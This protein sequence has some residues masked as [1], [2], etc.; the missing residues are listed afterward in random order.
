MESTLLR[1][2]QLQRSG[3]LV[4][5]GGRIPVDLQLSD[6]E[7]YPRHGY[8]ESAENRLNPETGS[9]VL[10]FVFANPDNA[11]IPGLFARVRLPVSR[12]QPT[13]LVQRT[14]DPGRT[15]ARNSSSRSMPA[16]PSSTARSPSEAR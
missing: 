15:R 2:N 9:L 16:T 5:E 8:V 13:L 7:A 3:S 14:G 1:F 6:E 4:T 11:L 12:P 10:R